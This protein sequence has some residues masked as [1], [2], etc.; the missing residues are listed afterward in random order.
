[1]ERLKGLHSECLRPKKSSFGTGLVSF[2]LVSAPECTLPGPKSHPT[3]PAPGHI[4]TIFFGPDG[5]RVFG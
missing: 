5:G 4:R 2:R 3:G 1:M